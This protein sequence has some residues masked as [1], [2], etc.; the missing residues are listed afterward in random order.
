APANAARCSPSPRC[1]AR[2]SARH[3]GRTIRRRRS[4]RRSVPCP[5]A[6]RNAKLLT[7]SPRAARDP[8]NNRRVRKGPHSR[9]ATTTGESRPGR[10]V[11][12]AWLASSFGVAVELLVRQPDAAYEEVVDLQGPQG[13]EAESARGGHHVVL[14]DA[15][16]RDAEASEELHA[17]GVERRAA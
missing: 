3:H 8:R 14:I 12:A 10:C 15:V 1:P 4:S 13:L 11:R 6:S 7:G 2:A 17:G 5:T 9:P 16:A